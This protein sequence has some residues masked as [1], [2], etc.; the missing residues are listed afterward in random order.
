MNED[1]GKRKNVNKGIEKFT[2]CTFI[3]YSNILFDTLMY[4]QYQNTRT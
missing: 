4:Y 1:Y 3:W 2:K